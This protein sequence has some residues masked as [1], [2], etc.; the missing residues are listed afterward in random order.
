MKN[1]DIRYPANIGIA[2]IDVYKA[3]RKKTFIN[4]A[5]YYIKVRTT[6]PYNGEFGFDW[7]DIDP[8]SGD[9]QKIQDVNISELEYYYKKPFNANDPRDLG[10]IVPATDKTG[11]N[12]TIKENYPIIESGKKVDI[13]W[14]LIKPTQSIQLSLEVNLTTATAITSE[15]ISITGD[16]FYDF[17]IVGGTKTG[18]KTEKSL[19]ADKEIFILKIKCLKESPENNYFILQQSSGD[20]PIKVGGFTMMENKI[21]KIK[22]RIIALVSSDGTQATKAKNLFQKFV[23][24]DILKYLNNNSLNQ[25]GYE[26]DIENQDMFDNLAT[27]N[28]DDYYYAFD[29]TEWTAKKYFGKKGTDEVI[30]ENQKDIGE[31]DKNNNLD[32]VIF[33]EYQTYLASRKKNYTGGIIILNDYLSSNPDSGAYSK[34]DPLNYYKLMVFVRNIDQKFTYCH[35]IGHMLGLQHLFFNTA[36]QQSYKVDREKILGNDLPENSPEYKSGVLK[37]ISFMEGST[38]A[39]FFNGITVGKKENILAGLNNLIKTMQKRYDDTKKNRDN[40]ILKY[41]NF[42]NSYK[43]NSTQTKGEYIAA[44]NESMNTAQDYNNAN[45]KAIKVLNKNNDY[46]YHTLTE[47]AY[48]L[49]KDAISLAKEYYECL[50]IVIKQDHDNYLMFKI[51][52]TQNIMDYNDPGIRYLHNQIKIMRDDYGNFTDLK[53]GISS[54]KAPLKKKK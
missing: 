2:D 47:L 24:A 46:G 27:A 12:D 23:K 40:V 14:V 53:K 8:S 10:N 33:E 54:P 25:A 51:R 15:A 31:P 44:C 17:E 13:P 19:T 11:V 29:K 1:I 48:F 52:T 16:E 4:T 38:G 45:K 6:P 43:I 50:K 32:T 3:R 21:Q 18:N 41:K 39:I 42:P 34:P 30:V 20:K 7:I 35:E 5:N 9:V 37:T 49:R 28:L 36:E 22:F 26:V